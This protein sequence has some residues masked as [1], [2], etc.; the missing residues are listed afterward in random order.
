MVTNKRKPN[1]IIISCNLCKQDKQYKCFS[2]MDTVYC[3]KLPTNLLSK[4]NIALQTCCTGLRI[5]EGWHSP[6]TAMLPFPYLS[7]II[8]K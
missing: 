3:I 6:V 1:R 7:Y 5:K 2:V 8:S 4:I